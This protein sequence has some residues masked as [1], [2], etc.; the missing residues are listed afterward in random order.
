M[1]Q[2]SDSEDRSYFDDCG[3]PYEGGASDEQDN[4][5]VVVSLELQ[6]P[7]MDRIR[8]SADRHGVSIYKCM[9]K[10]IYDFLDR[11]DKIAVARNSS[12]KHWHKHKI[13][14]MRN[15]PKKAP[16]GMPGRAVVP[17]TQKEEVVEWSP[18]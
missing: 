7:V 10:A 4:G 8:R 14:N 13:S 12:R 15:A 17:V 2:M 1:E 11:D 6:R 3:Y 18:R 9:R 5:S 16:K